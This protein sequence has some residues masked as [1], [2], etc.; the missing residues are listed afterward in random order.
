MVLLSLI[1]HFL[2]MLI[3]A[4]G[5]GISWVYKSMFGLLFFGIGVVTSVSFMV[6]DDIPEIVRKLKGFKHE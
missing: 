5:V 1:A 3:F 2:L 4:G 6:E